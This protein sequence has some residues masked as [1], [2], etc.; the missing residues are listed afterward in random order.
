MYLNRRP[1]FSTPQH[2]Y[3]SPRDNM[4]IPFWTN[5]A[6]RMSVINCKVQGQPLPNLFLLKRRLWLAVAPAIVSMS[7][8]SLSWLAGAKTKFNRQ[9]IFTW[10]ISEFSSWDWIHKALSSFSCI[11]LFLL[12]LQYRTV[13]LQP[14]CG[15]DGYSVSHNSD[16]KL[17]KKIVR[18]EDC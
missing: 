14:P 3:W 16:D 15:G 1:K 12:L 8:Q 17:K 9:L 18:S 5:K 7:R 13:K 4:S 6:I 10:N 2:I 11:V